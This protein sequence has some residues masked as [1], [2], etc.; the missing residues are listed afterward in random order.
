MK[1]TN[2]IYYFFGI[3]IIIPLSCTKET[4]D[5]SNFVEGYVVGSFKCHVDSSD[6][7]ATPLG[8]CILLEESQL[9]DTIYPM[10][11]YTFNMP[12]NV[13]NYPV[14][15]QSFH[16]NGNNCGPVFFPDSIQIKSKVRFRYKIL[17]EGDKIKFWCG[18][19][20]AWQLQFPWEDYNEISVKD[21]THV[22]NFN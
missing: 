5:W 13:V 11:F 17:N 14:D 12:Y 15:T 1:L 2:I 18:F 22:E 19:C 7:V 20:T 10:D 3:L 8:Y 9:T 16:S 6:K 4:S 21:I